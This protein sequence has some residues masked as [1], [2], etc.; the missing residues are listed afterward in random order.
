MRQ[1]SQ[2]ILCHND[3]GYGTIRMFGMTQTIVR[4][5]F[6]VPGISAIMRLMLTWF[7]QGMVCFYASDESLI[8]AD[9]RDANVDQRGPSN[10]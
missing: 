3:T 5:D 6:F 4:R 1:F 8:R 7:L 10:R 9:P 2:L